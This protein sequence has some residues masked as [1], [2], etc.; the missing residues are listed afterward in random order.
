MSDLTTLDQAIARYIAGDREEEITIKGVT[1]KF[2]EVSLSE[3]NRLRRQC[4]QETA[5]VTG[6]RCIRTMPLCGGKGL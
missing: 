5:A 4:L 3:L 2:A 1:V 6:K